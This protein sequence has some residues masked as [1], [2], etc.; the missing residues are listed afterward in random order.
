MARKVGESAKPAGNRGKG[1]KKGV[2]N[3]ATASVK[4]ALS[5]AFQGTGGVPALQAWAAEHQTEFY[6]LWAKM[7]PTD[8]KLD[9]DVR[10]GVVIL[11]PVAK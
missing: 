11:P 2:P 5:L 10:L 8:V 6:K 9:A 7:L 4:E 1:R 3:K